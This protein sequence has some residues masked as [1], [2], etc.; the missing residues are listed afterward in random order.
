MEVILENISKGFGFNEFFVKN[1]NLNIRSSDKVAL[2]GDSGSGKTSILNLIA[3]ID[4]P[5]SGKVIVGGNHFDNMD[6]NELVRFRRKNIGFVFQAFHLIPHL[7]IFQNI[8]LP[9]LLLDSDFEKI[10]LKV[11]NIIKTIGLEKRKNAFP[12]QLSGGEQQR[13]AI[14][15]SLI[16]DPGLILADEPTGN[17]DLKNTEIILDLLISQS[18]TMNSTLLVVTH[19]DIVSKKMSK[20]FKLD[21][22]GLVEIK[23]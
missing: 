19:S 10:K 1:I 21:S 15:R 9:C 11:D 7:N 12:D 17:L 13:V 3:G 23:Q 6:E 2:V 22:L 5:S 8:A 20:T 18:K 4:R 14:A 16:H